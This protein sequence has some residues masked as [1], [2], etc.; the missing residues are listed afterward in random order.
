MR[1]AFSVIFLTTLSGAGQ[2]LFIAVYAAQLA[3][4]PPMGF[5]FAGGLLAAGLAALGLFAS[6]FHLG[7][8]SAGWRAA[9]Q[10]R[11][12]WLSREVIALPLF[13]VSSFLYGVNG[14]P[15]LGA[16]A[17][18][19]C[20]ALFVCT[21]MIYAC[22][23]FLQEWASPL[24]LLNFAALGTASGFTLA[25]ALAA[26]FAP[27]LVAPYSAAGIA[28]TLLAFVAR[29]ASLARNAKLKARSTLQS[30]IGVA[31]P[32]IAQ[33]S[34][35]FTAGSFNTRE[36]FHGASAAK[37]RAVKWSFLLLTFAAPVALLGAGLALGSPAFLAVAFPVQY[38]GLL[39]ERWFFFAQAN[40]PQNLYYQAIA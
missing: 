2:G 11:T 14:S 32:R 19:V 10:W 35:G 20:V 23:K 7:R 40:N 22:L 15:L 39:A 29:A 27:T 16:I 18:A 3:A 4:R 12:S 31:H 24:T 1:P 9:S 17:L 5:L 21:A 33:R 8:L 13:V 38:L 37:L 25:A 6:L 26:L 30:A 28:L 34:Q 36:F